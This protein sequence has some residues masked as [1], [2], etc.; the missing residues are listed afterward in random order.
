MATI[1]DRIARLE[2]HRDQGQPI[3]G[4][5]IIPYEM[6]H[7]EALV[8]YERQHPGCDLDKVIFVEGKS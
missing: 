4:F 2:G 1:K 6:T 5:F 3:D 7:E 8:E